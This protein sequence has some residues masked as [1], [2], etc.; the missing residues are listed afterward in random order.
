M[1]DIQ[2]KELVKRYYTNSVVLKAGSLKGKEKRNYI[3]EIKYRMMYKNI[4][5][6][7]LKQKIKRILLKYSISLYLKMR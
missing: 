1:L 5:P 4:K 3:K 6:E 2:T 7:N